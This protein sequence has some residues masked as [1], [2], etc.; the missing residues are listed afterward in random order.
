MRCNRPRSGDECAAVTTAT[1]CDQLVACS[2]RPSA[3]PYPSR[4]SRCRQLRPRAA[5]L[6]N[7]RLASCTDAH[8]GQRGRMIGRVLTEAP[9]S[10]GGRACCD[11]AISSAPVVALHRDA[12]IST[13]G[14]GAADA[15]ASVGVALPGFW[16]SQERFKG[17]H[18]S[19]S[20]A[21][22]R[23]GA[24][25]RAGK[26]QALPGPRDLHADPHQWPSPVLQEGRAHLGDGR[27]GRS[28]GDAAASWCG[29]DGDR[30]ELGHRPRRRHDLEAVTADDLPRTQPINPALSRRVQPSDRRPRH[31]APGPSLRFRRARSRTRSEPRASG[32]TPRTPPQAPACSSPGALESCRSPASPRRQ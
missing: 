6:C 9:C 30:S 7:N 18:C 10:G 19:Q 17:R 4:R 21:L 22:A 16:A 25:G 8:H 15:G 11:L 26:H 23:G 27:D 3:A 5:G 28:R 14:R 13:T 12:V 2:V 24:G 29:C 20:D 1:V 31:P 32:E